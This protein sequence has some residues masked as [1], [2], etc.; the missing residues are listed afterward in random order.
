MDFWI[1]RLR[2]GHP[3]QK[4]VS[5]KL[6]AFLKTNL[7]SKFESDRNMF[8]TKSEFTSMDQY[9]G[10]FVLKLLSLHKYKFYQK[11]LLYSLLGIF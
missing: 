10:F 2:E 1:L 9:F 4:V 6:G 5:V 3:D 8:T 11:N 7:W